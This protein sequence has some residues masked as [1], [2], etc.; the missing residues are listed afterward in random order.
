MLRRTRILLGFLLLTG[1]LLHAQIPQSISIEKTTPNHSQLAC[2]PGQENFAG[3]VSLGTITAASNDIDLDTMFLCVNDTVGLVHNGDQSLVGDPNPATAAG[4]C[5]GFYTCAPTIS[6]PADLGTIASDPCIVPETAPGVDFLVILEGNNLNGDITLFN[7]G[8]FIDNFNG[9]NPFLVF[10][11]PVTFDELLDNMDGTFTPE[12]ENGGPCVHTNIDAAVPVV[13]LSEIQS[14][15]ITLGSGATSCSASFDL[16]GGL[17]HFDANETYNISVSLSTDPTITGSVVSA[18]LGH[19]ETAEVSVPQPGIYDVTVSDGKSCPHTFQIDMSACSDPVLLDVADATTEEGTTV[20]I[21]ITASNFTDIVSFQ[22]VLEYDPTMFNA[23]AI[24]IDNPNPLLGILPPAGNA[25]PEGNFNVLW[26]DFSSVGVTIPDG[27]ILFEFCLDAVGVN[28]DVSPVNIISGPS[29]PIEFVVI[30]DMLNTFVTSVSSNGGAAT[31]QSSAYTLNITS[32]DETC[33]GLNNGSFATTISNGIAPF[34]YT[35]F[36]ESN[37]I[38]NTTTITDADGAFTLT[39]LAPGTYTIQVE[40]QTANIISDQVIIVEGVDLD[41]FI[42]VTPATCN[43]GEGQMV[44]NAVVNSI[45]IN[46]PGPEYEFEWSTGDVGNTLTGI[47]AGTYSVTLTNTDLMCSESS[48][49]G[50][51]QTAPIL[52]AVNSI[53]DAS[54]SGVEDGALDIDISGGT[55]SIFNI[56]LQ[57]INGNQI[58]TSTGTN[59]TQAGISDGNYLVIAEDSLMCLDTSIV[60]IG[61]TISL[62]L[63]VT[64]AQEINCFGDC[65]GFINVDANTVGGTSN[66][67]TFNW[68]PAVNSTTTATSTAASDLCAGTYTLELED[69]LGCSTSAEY[70]ISEPD[71]LQAAVVDFQNE[72]CAVGNDGTITVAVSGG[73]PDY[74]YDWGALPQSDSIVTGLSAGTYTVTILDNNNCPIELTQDIVAP[75]PPV[76]NSF[77]DVALLCNGDTDGILEVFASAGANPINLYSWSTNNSGINLTTQDNLSAG[78]YIVTVED[79]AGCITVDTA[80]VTQPDVLQIV[81]FI[82]TSPLC[83]GL[84]NGVI[85]AQVEGGTEPYFYDWS[86]GIDGFG[87]S[88]NTGS[89]ITAGDYSVT[90]TDFNGCPTVDGNTTLEDP[91]AITATFINLVDVSCFDASGVPYDGQ[92]TAVAEYED[93]TVPAQLFSFIWSPSNE[94]TFNQLSSTAVALWQGTNTVSVSDGECTEEFTV[95]IGAPEELTSEITIDDVSCFGLSDGSAIA[96]GVGGTNPYTYLWEGTTAGATYENLAAGAY[97]VQITDDNGCITNAIATVQQ[98][99]TPLTGSIDLNSSSAEVSCFGETDG[100]ATVIAQGGNVNQGDI[101]YV[102]GPGVS[103]SITSS[104]AFDLAAGTYTV[105]IVDAEGCEFPLSFDIGSPDPITFNIPDIQPIPCPGETTTVT[106]DTAF[107]GNGTSNLSFTFSIDGGSPQTLGTNINV[108]PGQHIVTVT[109]VSDAGCESDTTFVLDGPSE[110][111]LEYDSPIEIELGASETITP[112]ILA[113][114]NPINPD[115][116][117]WTPADYLSFEDDPLV[118]TIEPLDDVEYTI[119]AY[120]INGCAIESELVIEVDKNRNVYIPNIFTPDGDGINDLFQPYV[121]RGVSRINYFRIYDRWGEMLHERLLVEDDLS[122]INPA[123]A[124]DGTFKGRAMNPGVYVYL[125]EIEFLDGRV[126]LYRGDISIVK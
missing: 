106:V 100:Y 14:S 57:D 125:A 19:T 22:F 119:L 75:T 95:E 77:D 80:E 121:G 41:V 50:L 78:Q 17:P 60:N 83:P 113:L 42:S 102:W 3:T 65:N 7:D 81:D 62:E 38:I 67:Y 124:W 37:N 123:I 110:I 51:P 98:P 1:G 104:S 34:D 85:Q 26:A 99:L 88:I 28:G 87:A 71:V 31:I 9:G 8:T 23:A 33:L 108:F 118:P 112:S 24:S 93:G 45:L 56:E 94:S 21:P 10:W 107:G 4:I 20:C 69:D 84:G 5:Y 63:N 66:S 97:P 90:I 46:N 103:A 58:S 76:I 111:V 105:T 109:E 70:V 89:N 32:T 25:N 48:T 122:Q 117:Y 91:P 115:S 12:Y 74:T 27:E 47:T 126:L 55:G 6:G 59:I 64:A 16:E 30:D 29:L 43:G 92:A 39:N 13:Y 35:I 96:Q 79:E 86:V 40:D 53:T 116:V 114:T 2:V 52:F 82:L 101:Q 54:C 120:D 11:S 72:T 61:S 73:V 49:D 18:P 44:A 36:D 68:I 15:N